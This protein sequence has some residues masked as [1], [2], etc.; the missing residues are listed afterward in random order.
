MTGRAAVLLHYHHQA[1]NDREKGSDQIPVT[2]ATR[3]A[4]CEGPDAHH[5][6]R[7][8]YRGLC[9]IGELLGKLPVGGAGARR[10]TAAERKPGGFDGASEFRGSQKS[11]EG[12]R[13]QKSSGS[14]PTTVYGRPSTWIAE[15]MTR[16]LARYSERQAG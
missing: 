14:T 6:R 13:A 11:T 1:A 7:A 5:A 4:V 9:E 10:A 15:P 3:E 2:V 12:E 8:G 16:G